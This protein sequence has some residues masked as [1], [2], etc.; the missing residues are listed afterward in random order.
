MIKLFILHFLGWLGLRPKPNDKLYRNLRIGQNTAYSHRNLDGL[1]PGLIQMGENCILAPTA[2]ILT[3]DASSFIHVGKYRV[4]PVII[5]D[6]CFIGYNA[7][8][9]PGVT[10][11]SDVIVAAGAVV[12]RDVP[13]GSVVAGVPGKI[14]GQTAEVIAKWTVEAVLV[15][16][17][18]MLGVEPGPDEVCVLQE[19]ALAKI[20]PFGSLI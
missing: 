7:V 14:V 12:T 1:T 3:H 2:V 16:P 17:P 6:R 13:S 11:G 20:G 18:F 5:G 15:E 19:R 10:L 8:V 9:M 4:A